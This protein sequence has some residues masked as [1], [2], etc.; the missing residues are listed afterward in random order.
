MRR[1]R[2]MRVMLAVLGGAVL[3][4]AGPALAACTIMTTPVNFGSYNVFASSP[5]D[6][7]GQVS[8]RCT[9][10]L[11]LFVQVTLDK[12]GAATFS[13]RRLLK[14]GETLT[15]N[16]YLDASRSVIWGDGTGG[17]QIYSQLIVLSLLGQT[18]TIPVYG[19]IPAGQDV[20]AGSYTNTVVTTINF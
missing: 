12:G 4:T 18:I 16:L 9:G 8:L 10:I 13:P 1:F 15:Y 6:S 3:G 14:G 5:L 2:A 20:S 19:R 7:I 17:T 11:Q